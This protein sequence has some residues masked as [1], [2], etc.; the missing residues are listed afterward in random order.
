VVPCQ[1]QGGGPV[2]T[3]VGALSVPGWGPSKHTGRGVP[4][5]AP[6]DGQLQQYGEGQVLVLQGDVSFGTGTSINIT[7]HATEPR[8]T[9]RTHGYTQRTTTTCC[10]DTRL[11]ATRGLLIELISWNTLQILTIKLHDS[12][13]IVEYVDVC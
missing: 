11:S 13:S 5:G 12:R 6:L 2:S 9:H 10:L 7:G 3:R 8:G 1:H 4:E